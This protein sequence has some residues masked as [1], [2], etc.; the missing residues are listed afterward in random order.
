MPPP[1]CLQGQVLLGEHR[2]PPS[3][4]QMQMEGSGEDARGI[5]RRHAEQAPADPTRQ[6]IRLHLDQAAHPRP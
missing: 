4:L 2:L 1:G 5:A 3:S 6:R